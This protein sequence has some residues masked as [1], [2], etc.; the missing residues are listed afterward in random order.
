[1]QQDLARHVSL[2]KAVAPEQ[3]FQRFSSLQGVH[4]MKWIAEA[5]LRGARLFPW[6]GR[7]FDA[8]NH[9]TTDKICSSCNESNSDSGGFGFDIHRNIG[10][11][12]GRVQILNGLTERTEL[13]DRSSPKGNRPTQLIAAQRLIGWFEADGADNTLTLIFESVLKERR[14]R[15]AWRLTSY[16]NRD[17]HC[18]RER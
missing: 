7:G 18:E 4:S 12:T 8:V 9:D 2:I 6:V 14:V 15:C 13:E 10:E 16:W 1:M 17:G 11:P 5:Q 3:S